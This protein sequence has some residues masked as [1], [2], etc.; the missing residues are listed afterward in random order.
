M[1]HRLACLDESREMH[2]R[3]KTL[4]LKHRPESHRIASVCLNK[5]GGGGNGGA[6]SHAEVVEHNG[7]V[8]A[9][10]QTFCHGTTYISGSAGHQNFHSGNSFDY[11]LK[12]T[13]QTSEMYIGNDVLQLSE[14]LRENLRR[15]IAR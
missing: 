8:P 7:V 2:H 3:V 13:V 15:A 14:R 11:L 1:L 4:R 6:P 5:P 9:V 10:K 12:A